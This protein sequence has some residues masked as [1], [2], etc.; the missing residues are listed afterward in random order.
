MQRQVHPSLTVKE[1]AL[2]YVESLML[3]LLQL[4]CSFQPHSTQDVE[5]R[6]RRTFPGP[7]NKW[8]IRDAHTVLDKGRKGPS[9]FV[10]MDQFQLLLKVTVF[11]AYLALYCLT[12]LTKFI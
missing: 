3:Q 9:L 11:N 6:V 10:S 1:D 2:E 7:I 4:L 12:D 5:D 8:A